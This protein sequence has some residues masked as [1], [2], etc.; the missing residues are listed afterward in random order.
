[1]RRGFTLIELMIVIVIMAAVYA[2]ML[3]NFSL[4]KDK[5]SQMS[6]ENLPAYLRKI[7]PNEE[8]KVTYRCVN[9]CQ[10]CSFLVG[11]KEVKAKELLF[12]KP[13]KVYGFVRGRLE[14]K[15][16][17]KGVCFEY[18]LYPNGSSD[19]VV[20]EYENRVYLYANIDKKT[21]IFS[22][23][24]RASEYIDEAKR[25]AFED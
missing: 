14:K 4:P 25:R 3:Q 22:D 8:K 17:Q 2:L 6:I 21:A 12:E 9:K 10:K 1:M 5:N 11:R 24:D 23:K 16:F 19:K 13:P 15:E 7:Y 18:L 20:L